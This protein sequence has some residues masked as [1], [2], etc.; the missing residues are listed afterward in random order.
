[1]LGEH[2]DRH[3]AYRK[4]TRCIAGKNATH[5][6]QRDLNNRTKRDP[7]GIKQRYYPV[8]GFGS[9]ASVS[10]FCAAVDGLRACFRMRRRCNENVPPA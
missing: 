2:R 3:S 8:L 7:R 6:Q 9:F 1:M 5:R 10:R 4:A